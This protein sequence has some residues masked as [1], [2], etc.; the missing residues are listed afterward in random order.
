MYMVLIY[1]VSLSL[2]CVCACGYIYIRYCNTNIIVECMALDE[3]DLYSQCYAGLAQFRCAGEHK[4]HGFLF[5]FVLISFLS[6][7]PEQMSEI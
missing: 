7:N 3:S 6:D 1:L 5:C 4:S 2:L